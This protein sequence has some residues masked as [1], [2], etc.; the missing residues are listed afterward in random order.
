MVCVVAFPV[1]NMISHYIECLALLIL[2]RIARVC[3][4]PVL[5]EWRQWSGLALDH[6]RQA[7]MVPYR[8]RKSRFSIVPV[9]TE[10]LAA[11]NTFSWILYLD[12]SHGLLFKFIPIPI[13]LLFGLFVSFHDEDS[14]LGVCKHNETTCFLMR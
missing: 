9:P 8:R 2:L 13:L 5:G 14:R 10:L 7:V 6:A 12:R 3:L 4:A 1:L 11:G